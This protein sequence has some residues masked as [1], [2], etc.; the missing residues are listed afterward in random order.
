MQSSIDQIQYLARA[1]NAGISCSPLGRPDQ[2]EGMARGCKRN[3]QFQHKRLSH[4]IAPASLAASDTE[5]GNGPQRIPIQ[6]L[7]DAR[8]RGATIQIN[9][10]TPAGR[11]EEPFGP[12][13]QTAGSHVDSQW[14]DNVE[15]T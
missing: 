4:P 10:R 3:S 6:E 14:P 11:T 7:C 9:L 15:K 5:D 1:G 13:I 2:H 12:G 8:D